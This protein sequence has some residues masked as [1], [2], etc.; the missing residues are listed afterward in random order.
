MNTHALSFT[1]NS[2]EKNFD[3]EAEHFK[4]GLNEIQ[5]QD[6]LFDEP[7][8]LKNGYMIAKVP[9]MW[10]ETIISSIKSY[11]LNALNVN[12]VN[13]ENFQLDQYHTYVNDKIH[14]K[15]VDS[16]RG[17]MDGYNGIPIEQL[18]IPIPDIDSFINKTIQ[19]NRPVSIHVQKLG[20]SIKKF[21]IRIIRPNTNDNN[22]PH[23][24]SHLERNRNMVISFYPIVGCNEK[25]SLPIIPGS[26]LEP[27]SEYIVSSSPSFVDKKEF[28][29]PAIV[30]RNK[31]L[32]LIT[33]NPK[34]GE[35]LIFTPELIHGGGVNLNTNITRISLEMRYFN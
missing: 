24:D 6:P 34:E 22:P 9:E 7:S 31:G 35:I 16:F 1:V 15:V 20:L 23:K 29:V 25:S 14:Q 32:N 8:F 27:E 11:I 33:P 2:I 18:N 13:P 5:L 21:W 26:H 4:R 10:H 19:S 30:H 12:G 3:V 17:G 28:N